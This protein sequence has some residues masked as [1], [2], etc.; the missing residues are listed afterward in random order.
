[1]GITSRSASGWLGFDPGVPQAANIGVFRQRW[2]PPDAA[3]TL[4]GNCAGL[5]VESWVPEPGACYE[6]VMGPVEV[7]TAADPASAV[8][9]TLIVGEFVAV[10]GRTATGWLFVNGN[11][12]N[13]SGVTGFIPELEMNANGPCDSIPVISS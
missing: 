11:D 9:H 13:V 6:M 3:V 12:G 2:I 4:T 5:P 7:H 1:M 10:T 8:S